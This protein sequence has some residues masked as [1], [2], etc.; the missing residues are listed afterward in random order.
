MSELPKIDVQ[1][2]P[3][4]AEVVGRKDPTQNPTVVRLKIL[5][6]ELALRDEDS[7]RGGMLAMRLNDQFTRWFKE[8]ENHCNESADMILADMTR[9]SLAYCTGYHKGADVLVKVI[10][11]LLSTK[12]MLPAKDLST[13]IRALVTLAR[14][15]MP[16]P[17]PDDHGFGRT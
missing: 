5:G 14:K 1:K 16:A 12:E 6:V 13:A 7:W 2:P 11:L 15:E 3:V 10:D 8:I 9:D 4:V 17:N